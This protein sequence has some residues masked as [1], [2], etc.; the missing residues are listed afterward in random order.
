[1]KAK[2]KHRMLMG[3]CPYYGY[4]LSKKLI[5]DGVVDYSLVSCYKTEFAV[6][7]DGIEYIDEDIVRF[8]R[9]EKIIDFDDLPALGKE[10]LERM[11]PYES[12]CI[13][14]GMRR[15][16]YPIIEYEAEKINYH[17]HLRFWNYMIEKKEIDI[18]YF[19]EIPHN[20]PA[21][22]VIYALAQIKRIP[23]FMVGFSNIPGIRVYGNSL[24]GLGN[25][26]SEYYKKIKIDNSEDLRLSGKVKD[27]YETKLD[28]LKGGK[29]TKR[30]DK[31]AILL[32]Y[33]GRFEDE[34]VLRRYW[35]I[36]FRY[37][38]KKH[39]KE[40]YY[41]E[42]AFLN[43]YKYIRDFQRR[44]RTSLKQY[45]ALSIY[46]DFDK[47]YIYFP[48]QFIPESSTFPQAGVFSEQYTAIQLISRVAEKF[49]INVYVKEH[50]NQPF[51]PKNFY[52]QLENNRNI[53]FIKS[54][55]DSVALMEHSI[56]VATLTGTCILESALIGKPCI[57]ASGGRF[58]KGIPNT[59]EIT[60]E[61]QGEELISRILNGVD[62][63]SKEVKK[64]FYAI[65]ETCI[66]SYE[67]R[68][69]KK[70]YVEEFKSSVEERVNKIKEYINSYL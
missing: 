53:F 11:L 5:E 63:S 61:K 7:E 26:I 16:N 49:G 8:A 54:E 18:V 28:E 68:S 20:T 23:I 52:G 42:K 34:K 39:K 46:P 15:T 51:R 29:F 37:L 40:D 4:A 24:F 33:F 56:A 59:F 47:K 22:Y 65:Q 41:E 31:N 60:D 35:R 10:D 69:W 30:G 1:M 48:L 14:L 6:S 12:M 44:S 3:Y 58:W 27:F 13:K 64:Y 21:E 2:T 45:D 43:D 38:L 50:Y 32:G 25:N 66:T 62:I 57:V 67:P 70:Q 9:Y 36:Y 17:K 55:V 19:D